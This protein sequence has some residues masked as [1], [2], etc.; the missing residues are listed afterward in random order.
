MFSKRNDKTNKL[1]GCGC[2]EEGWDEIAVILWF[3]KFDSWEIGYCIIKPGN[4]VEEQ[5]LGRV[6]LTLFAV[7]GSHP[8]DKL[9]RLEFGRKVKDH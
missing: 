6:W 4:S 2:N 7:R 3:C 1:M 5:M 8:D 9:V